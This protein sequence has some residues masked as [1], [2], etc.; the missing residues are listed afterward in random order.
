ME[1]EAMFS[2]LTVLWKRWSEY[3]VVEQAFNRR[4]FRYLVP[5][6][7]ATEVTY[8]CAEHAE[9]MVADALELGRQ[10]NMEGTDQDRLCADFAVRYGLLGPDVELGQAIGE[11]PDTPPPFRPVG[12]IEYG[13]DMDSFQKEFKHLYQHFLHANGEG[14]TP[15]GELTGLLPYRLTAGRTPQLIWEIKSLE[16]V[17]RLTYAALITAPSRSLKICKN[18]GRVYYNPRAKSEFCSTRCRNYYNV[19]MYR[20]RER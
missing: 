5:V 18:C 8:N 3:R 6:P 1:M 13:E 16:S 12:T 17:L 2:D 9:Q 7:G 14:E 20:E 4:I 10:L 19:K 11:E 15:V